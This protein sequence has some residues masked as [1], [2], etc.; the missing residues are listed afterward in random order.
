MRTR[1]LALAVFSWSALAAAQEPPAVEGPPALN[2]LTLEECTTRAIANSKE[3]AAARHRLDAMQAQIE[4]VWWAP[5]SIIGV[6]AGFSFVPDRCVDTGTLANDGRLVACNG[7]AVA[8]E[9]DWASDEWGPTFQLEVKGVLPILDFVRVTR[10]QKA[11]EEAREA[12][13]AQLPSLKQQVRYNVER[14]YHAIIGARE[15]A[16]TLG[17]G[18]KQL[19]K[20]RELLEENLA[21][22]EG[23][24]TETDLIKLKVFEAQVGYMEQQTRQIERTA[25]AALRFLVGGEDAA[26]VDVPEDPQSLIE[27]ELDPLEA[28]KKRALENR[29]ELEAL[30]HGVK[31]LELKVAMRKAEFLPS[32]GLV[33]DWRYAATPG[34]TDIG[35]WLLKD[36]YNLNYFVLALALS[37]DLDLGLDIYKLDEAKAELAALTADQE[38]ALEAIVLDVENTY[39]EVTSA[40]DS[41][42][43]LEKSKR[44]AKGWI[45]AAVQSNAA[46]LGPAKE[47]KDALKEYF[48]IM[49]SI[50]QLTGE[51]NVGLAKLDKVTGTLGEARE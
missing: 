29:P 45:A 17:E 28:Y 34:R 36:N 3:L 38:N 25:L 2:R 15:M 1:L 23:T 41:L 11:L 33:A 44:L 21:K 47:V 31:A 42:A 22:Q 26:R 8:A 49:A 14:A 51:Y 9:E 7:G 50:H 19:V 37:Y 20:A 40:R 46:G 18:K 39:V 43:E 32:L 35:N 16:Y 27:R 6:D 12:K 5:F 30:R 13:A 48:Q 4:Q 10:A 24:E